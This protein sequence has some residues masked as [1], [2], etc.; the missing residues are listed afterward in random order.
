MGEKK[1]KQKDIK[2]LEDEAEIVKEVLDLEKSNIEAYRIAKNGKKT[3]YEEQLG[4]ISK[5]FAS[6]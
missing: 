2:I 3:K 5:K 6:Q 4:E 1:V